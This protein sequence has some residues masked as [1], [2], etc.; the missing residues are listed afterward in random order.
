MNT[1]N[2]Y[3]WVGIGTEQFTKF[4]T[5]SPPSIFSCVYYRTEKT[6]KIKSAIVLT[7]SVEIE[8]INIMTIMNSFS[9]VV[10]E[11]TDVISRI[12]YDVIHL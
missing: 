11:K 1:T 2:M 7:K 12:L 10:C 5:Q 4:G 9:P 3:E 8:V 6:P